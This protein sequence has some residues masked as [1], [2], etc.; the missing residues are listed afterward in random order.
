MRVGL[1][2]EVLGEGRVALCG[3]GDGE[4]WSDEG[5][6]LLAGCSGCGVGYGRETGGE[7]EER[8]AVRHRGPFEGCGAIGGLLFV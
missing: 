8:E 7:A 2:D 4:G 1:L 5:E 3:D 6:G